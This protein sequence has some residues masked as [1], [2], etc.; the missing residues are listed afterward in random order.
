[1]YPKNLIFTGDGS[2][3]EGALKNAL[4]K[5]T[6]SV[7]RTGNEFQYR[8]KLWQIWG[9]VKG[10]DETI[11]FTEI[12][13]IETTSSKFHVEISTTQNGTQE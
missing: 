2:S 8:W 5:A 1:M 10:H 9:S 13:H 7:P 3:F 12:T 4:D 11:P 6:A